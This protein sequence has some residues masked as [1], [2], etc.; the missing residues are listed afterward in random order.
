MELNLQLANSILDSSE[1]KLL[2]SS[3]TCRL[4]PVLYHSHHKSFFFFAKLFALQSVNLNVSL[5]KRVHLVNGLVN[6][7]TKFL[8]LYIFLFFNKFYIFI[9]HNIGIWII[10]LSTVFFTSLIWCLYFRFFIFFLWFLE[11]VRCFG[12]FNCFIAFTF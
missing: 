1:L 8:K 11:K 10:T 4:T 5:K 7:F 9:I 2:F 6:I 3:G 12:C